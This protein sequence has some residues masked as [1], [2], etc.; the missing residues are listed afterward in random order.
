MPIFR[1]AYSVAYSVA[2]SLLY[3]KTGCTDPIFQISVAINAKIQW[4]RYPFCT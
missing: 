4:I 2:Y 3:Q 1:N